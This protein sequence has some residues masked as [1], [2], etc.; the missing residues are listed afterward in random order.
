MNAR[1]KWLGVESVL[2]MHDEQIAEHG[3]Q[4][5]MPAGKIGPPDRH[6]RRRGISILP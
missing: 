3:G 1:P 6:I 4:E 2:I 5:R